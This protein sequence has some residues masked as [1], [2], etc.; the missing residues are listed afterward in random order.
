VH[1]FARAAAPLERFGALDGSGGGQSFGVLGAARLHLGIA[2]RSRWTASSTI[3]FPGGA[4]ETFT[5]N[6]S[7]KLSWLSLLYL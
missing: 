2:S 1:G 6:Q 7:G 5:L 3:T 4:T